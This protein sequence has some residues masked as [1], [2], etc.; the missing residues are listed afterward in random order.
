MP[1]S[2]HVGLCG[3]QKARGFSRAGGFLR[4]QAFWKVKIKIFGAVTAHD[5]T[6]YAI[7]WAKARGK[8]AVLQVACSL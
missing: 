5:G 1:V 4:D 3:I 8:G 2:K 6:V 7:G